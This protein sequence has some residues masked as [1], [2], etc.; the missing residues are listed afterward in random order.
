MND[1]KY[2]HSPLIATIAAFIVSVLLVSCGGGGGSST[3]TNTAVSVTLAA[4]VAEVSVG[5]SFLLTW[6]SANATSCEASGSEGWTGPVALSGRKWLSPSA[7]GSLNLVLTCTG[8]AGSATGNAMVAVNS[9]A[10]P[11]VNNVAQ[12]IV[13]KG[14]LNQASSI[15]LPF[16]AVTICRPG[17]DICQTIDHVLVDTGSYGLRIVGP[18]V[19]DSTLALPSINSASGGALAECAQF[20]SG[21]TWGSVNSADVRL[22]GEVARSAPIEVI[23][24]SNALFAQIPESCSSA[25]ANMSTVASLGANGILGVGLFKEDCGTACVSQAIPGTYYACNGAGC[26]ETV[27]SLDKQVVNP[28]ALFT[29]NNNGVAI[30]LPGVPVGGTSSLMGKL[31][32]GVGTQANNQLTDK[33]I[34]AASPSGLFTTTYKGKV[35]QTSFLDSGSNGI[36]FPDT[37]I[38]HCTASTGFYCPLS[39]ITL[40]AVNAAFDN[41]ASGTVSFTLENVDVLGAATVAASIGGNAAPFRF[42]GFDWGLPF[43]FGRTVFVTM[44]KA[45][46]P[47]GTGPFWA[48]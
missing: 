3:P 22:A 38:P 48:Y 35:Y 40:S 24:N 36:F 31:I 18:G 43:F 1:S 47:G 11:F 42:S 29:Q 44:E 19:I 12:I 23:G 45:N 15:N 17:T 27:V 46:T 34:Y 20:V 14:P 39:P 9:N 2:K 7:A 37:G 10:L 13:D 32:F 33:T 6:S 4:S 8:A 25:G 41:T 30:E 16:V 21:F 26:T 5:Q 28:V